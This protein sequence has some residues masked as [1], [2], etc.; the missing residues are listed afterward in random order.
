VVAGR[1]PCNRPRTRADR[2]CI[3]INEL[4][5]LADTAGKEVGCLSGEDLRTAIVCCVLEPLLDPQKHEV[6]AVPGV[7]RDSPTRA[8]WTPPLR[9]RAFLA[10]FLTPAEPSRRGA[11]TSDGRRLIAALSANGRAAVIGSN[12]CAP[13]R[14]PTACRWPPGPTPGVACHQVTR[15]PP[16]R[17]GRRRSSLY[18]LAIRRTWHPRRN[19]SVRASA[20][21]PSSCSGVLYCMV[22]RIVPC[23]VRFA[24]GLQKGKAIVTATDR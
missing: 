2:R 9:L 12:A 3:D 16:H 8:E 17:T 21:F 7:T 22:P 5:G 4:N 1:S 13:G 15:A 20:S 11:W 18:A 23:A 14:R 19:R 6:K 24:C 10:Y